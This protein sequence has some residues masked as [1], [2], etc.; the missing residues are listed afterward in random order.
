MAACVAVADFMTEELALI[1][2]ETK[3]PQKGS[4]FNS[5]PAGK[6]AAR[7]ASSG[8]GVF[9]TWL[10]VRN[11]VLSTD[12]AIRNTNSGIRKRMNSQRIMNPYF[13]LVL[14]FFAGGADGF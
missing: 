13:F 14:P 4:F 11:T 2:R 5:P 9:T 10:N 7:G 6:F 8:S 3:V 12:L 1:P